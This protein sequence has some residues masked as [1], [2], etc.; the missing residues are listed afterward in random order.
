MIAHELGHG[1]HE[2]LRRDFGMEDKH[3][4][5]SAEVIRWFVEAKAGNMACLDEFRARRLEDHIDRILM[6]CNY[7]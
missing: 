5:D 3:T 7:D 4:E 1:F 6:S 2:C